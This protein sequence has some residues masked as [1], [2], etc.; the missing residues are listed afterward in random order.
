M[1]VRNIIQVMK[2]KWMRHKGCL[3]YMNKNTHTALW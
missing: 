1:D 2:S 3:P